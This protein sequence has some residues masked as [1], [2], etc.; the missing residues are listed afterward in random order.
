MLAD[1]EDRAILGMMWQPWQS[2]RWRFVFPAWTVSSSPA[3][4]WLHLAF[5]LGVIGIGVVIV[6]GVSGWWSWIPIAVLVAVLVIDVG[7][8]YR[9]RRRELDNVS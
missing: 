7:L 1:Q 6:A 8:R 3:R 5:R 9:A 4:T 2:R